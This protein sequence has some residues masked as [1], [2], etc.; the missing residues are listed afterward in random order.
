[1]KQDFPLHN[2][3][4]VQVQVGHPNKHEDKWW[5]NKKLQK[6]IQNIRVTERT[7]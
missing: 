7:S 3:I 2:W 4:P 6:I 1:M 5:K